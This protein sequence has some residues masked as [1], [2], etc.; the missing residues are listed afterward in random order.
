[1]FWRATVAI[2]ALYYVTVPAEDRQQAESEL[3]VA[4]GQMPGHAIT[5]CQEKPLLCTEI[6]RQAGTVLAPAAPFA[7]PPLPAATSLPATI[8]P[9]APEPQARSA[10]ERRIVEGAPLPPRRPGP[11]PARKGA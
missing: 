5:L 2:A 8:P 11:H 1:M 7:A 3:R 6:A 9:T 10:P 4:A